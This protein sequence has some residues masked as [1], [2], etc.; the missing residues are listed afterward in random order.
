[1]RTLK[2]RLEFAKLNEEQ[3]RKERKLKQLFKQMEE[4]MQPEDYKDTLE[5]LLRIIRIFPPE[6]HEELMDALLT[7]KVAPADVH[8]LIARREMKLK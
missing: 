3:Q 4:N 6:K 7:V 8:A 1:M 2:Y 5:Q